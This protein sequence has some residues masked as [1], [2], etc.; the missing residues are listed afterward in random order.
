[1]KSTLFKKIKDNEMFKRIKISSLLKKIKNGSPKLLKKTKN[2]YLG[3]SVVTVFGFFIIILTLL[4]TGFLIYKGIGTFVVQKHSIFEFLFSNKFAPQD[5]VGSTQKGQVGAAVFIAGSIIISLF[6]LL[7]AT[8]FAI[9]AAIFINE[10]SPRLGKRFLQ[11]AIEI[12]VGIP[13]VVYGWIGLSILVPFIANIFKLPYGFNVL[14]G[15]IVLSLM[16]FPTITS[17]SVDAIRNVPIEYKEASYSLGSTRWQMIRR[18]QIRSALPGILTGVVLGLTRAFGEALAVAMVIGRREQF[19]KFN[20]GFLDGLLSATSTLTSK[21]ASDMGNTVTGSEW[22]NAL[23]SMALLLF[24]IS[25][26]FIILIRFLSRK[27]SRQ[28][29]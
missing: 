26:L 21:I 3:R 27:G 22:N 14:S 25:F 8:P 6:A 18:I 28:K 15:A 7:I 19:P 9:A 5:I 29:V 1:M 24:I 11:P 20:N 16:I 4:I 13:S 17:I 2:E 10:I 23:W 12:F